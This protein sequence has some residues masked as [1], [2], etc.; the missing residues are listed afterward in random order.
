ME[1]VSDLNVDPPD[2]RQVWEAQSQYPFHCR[3]FNPPSFPQPGGIKEIIPVVD[4]PNKPIGWL[5]SDNRFNWRVNVI[6]SHDSVQK[7]H[8][9]IKI[10]TQMKMERK[11][12]KIA[13][14]MLVCPYPKSY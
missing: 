9:I 5:V 10:F 12:K 1:S 2:R 7:L 4:K 6:K 3:T 11:E 8:F 14:A 13:A